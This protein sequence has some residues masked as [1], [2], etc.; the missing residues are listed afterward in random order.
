MWSESTDIT[1]ITTTHSRSRV[2]MEALLLHPTTLQSR[3]PTITRI[4]NPTTTVITRRVTISK[5]ITT[6]VTPPSQEENNL[7]L[8]PTKKRS[9]GLFFCFLFTSYLLIFSSS[10]LLSISSSRI[11]VSRL[12]AFITSTT[13]LTGIHLFNSVLL[14]QC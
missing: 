7:M 2:G 6:T 4:H 8:Y 3:S 5:G 12:L 9:T 10:Y 13:I 1:E 14:P 11:L